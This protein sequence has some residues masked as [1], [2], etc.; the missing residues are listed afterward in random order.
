MG[1]LPKVSRPV[2]AGGVVLGLGGG[3][4]AGE[5]PG[6]SAKSLSMSAYAITS[7][8]WCIV[9]EIAAQDQAKTLRLRGSAS[10]GCWTM[11]A[12]HWTSSGFASTSSF[13]GSD[14]WYV[15]PCQGRSLSCR[16]EH[17][18]GQGRPR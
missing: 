14:S 8:G 3:Q 15:T 16:P 11:P 9:T 13:T 18:A 2:G 10:S 7:A 17:Q 6:W 1:K 5:L 4:Y 12:M